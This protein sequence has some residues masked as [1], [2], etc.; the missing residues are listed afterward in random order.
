MTQP[1]ALEIFNMM[2]DEFQ[3]QN[4]TDI[5]TFTL[6]R[7]EKQNEFDDYESDYRYLDSAL[8]FRE[9]EIEAQDPGSTHTALKKLLSASHQYFSLAR[10]IP[11]R[12]N[13]E[14]SKLTSKP[15]PPIIM[16]ALDEKQVN[17]SEGLTHKRVNEMLA[18]I[19]YLEENLSEEKGDEFLNQLNF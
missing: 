11:E 6:Q 3:R 2:I 17:L 12:F 10:R 13:Q 18:L 14:L 4:L 7:I 8:A 1:T 16:Y 5:G 19:E 9:L 15:A